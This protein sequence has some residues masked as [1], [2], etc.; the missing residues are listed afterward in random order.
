MLAVVAGCTHRVSRD[1]VHLYEG[2]Q[3]PLDELAIIQ[4]TGGLFSACCFIRYIAGPTPDAESEHERI[5]NSHNRD[6]WWDRL[7]L[8]PG[9]YWI[10]A[11]ANRPYRGGHGIGF[12]ELIELKAGHTYQLENGRHG[13]NG[14]YQ[15]VWLEDITTRE[16]VAGNI[17]S[18]VLR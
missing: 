14:K 17:P 15:V 9:R 18:E 16:V 1:D 10:T 7:V 12:T 4:E 5:Y 8:L 3:R 11:N 6:Y 2:P 13:T